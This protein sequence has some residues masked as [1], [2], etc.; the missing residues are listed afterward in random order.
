MAGE[1]YNMRHS[2]KNYELCIFCVSQCCYAVWYSNQQINIWGYFRGKHLTM[3]TLE[4][5]A[6]SFAPE[7][8]WFHDKFSRLYTVPSLSQLFLRSPLSGIVACKAYS[9]LSPHLRY[10]M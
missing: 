5:A 7:G 3:R 1:K 4:D 8:G 2:H 9:I 10:H 6:E